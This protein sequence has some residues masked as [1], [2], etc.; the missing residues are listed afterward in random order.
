MMNSFLTLVTM[1]LLVATPVAVEGRF[2]NKFLMIISCD[3]GVKNFLV[4][5]CCFCFLTIIH[6]FR[7]LP[8]HRR[9]GLYRK[10]RCDCREYYRRGVCMWCDQGWMWK[11]GLYRVVKPERGYCLWAVREVHCF[12]SIMRQVH[13]RNWTWI[14]LSRISERWWSLRR[15][16]LCDWRS[17]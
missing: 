7:T 5:F 16:A 12:F 13:P 3:S 11:R 1:S 2:P 9:V 6:V 8:L 17:F 14:K 10:C 4:L 15:E